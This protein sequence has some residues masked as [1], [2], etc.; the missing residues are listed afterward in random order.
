MVREDDDWVDGWLAMSEKDECRGK[1]QHFYPTLL[2]GDISPLSALTQF[3]RVE[4]NG[5]S[6]LLRIPVTTT[7]YSSYSS[8]HT[9]LFSSLS[10]SLFHS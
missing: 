5:C 2:R 1:H 7:M 3:F 9:P 10:L 6:E 4:E 8:T